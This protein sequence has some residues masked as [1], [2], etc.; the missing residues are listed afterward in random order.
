MPAPSFAAIDEPPPPPTTPR[1]HPPVPLSGQQLRQLQQL[2]NQQH[3]MYQQ[4]YNHMQV[5]QQGSTTSTSIATNDGAGINGIG[6]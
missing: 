5:I 6:D 4:Q 3:Q 1:P 2:H